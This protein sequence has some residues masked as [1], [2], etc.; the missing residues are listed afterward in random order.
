MTDQPHRTTPYEQIGGTPVLTALATRFYD[1]MDSDPA[2]ARLRALHSADLEPIR[3]GL[4]G[5]LIGW[6]GGPRDWFE[7]NPNRC[8]GS[9]HRHLAIDADLARQWADCMA[10]AI[11]EAG[12]ADPEV[13]Q[14]L[15]DLMSR[16]AYGM[17]RSSLQAAE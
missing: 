13:A 15:T 11:A 12:P 9:M 7:A 17:V 1:R 2:Y 3:D 14:A 6:T 16:M 5:F 8:M 10:G 4:A